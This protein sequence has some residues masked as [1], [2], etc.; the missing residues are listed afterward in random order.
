MILASTHRVFPAEITA[1]T[2]D[3]SDWRYTIRSIHPQVVWEQPNLKPSVRVGRSVD[4]DSAR[5]G[6]LVWVYDRPGD[7]RVYLFE[8]VP[9]DPC[10]ENPGGVQAPKGNPWSPASLYA[11][12]KAWRQ[13]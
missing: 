13:S 10:E 2:G 3:A 12:F 11:R 8:G 5:V 6:D 7:L 9:F 4:L 1:R